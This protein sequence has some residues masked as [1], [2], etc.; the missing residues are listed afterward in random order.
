[1]KNQE[2]TRL[3]KKIAQKN[4]EINFEFISPGTPQKNGVIEQGFAAIYYWIH[5]MMDHSGLP[6][7]INTVL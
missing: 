5:T 1:M 7:N 2:K 6:E 3:L 4:E